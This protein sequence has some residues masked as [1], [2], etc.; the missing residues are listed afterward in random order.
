MTTADL[1]HPPSP[2]RSP[3]LLE[4]IRLLDLLE[5]TGNALQTGELLQLSQP[6]ISRHN[7]RLAADLGLQQYP[8]CAA[9]PLRYGDGACLRL[10]RRASKRHRLDAGVWRLG[11]D[12][13]GHGSLA[14]DLRVLPVPAR[15]RPLLEW[16]A[17][18]R[19][20]LLDGA[21]VS[22]EE[23]RLHCS[24]L[25]ANHQHPWAWEGCML[26]P[27]GASPLQLVQPKPLALEGPGQTVA[28]WSTVLMPALSS[29][30]GLAGRL[31]QQQLRPIHLRS[32]QQQPEHWVEALAERAHYALV[33]PCWLQQ[34]QAVST[35]PLVSVALPKALVMEH[36]LLVHRRDWGKHGGLT[37]MTASLRDRINSCIPQA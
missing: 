7:R 35:R 24:D 12:G 13:W 3:E 29:C 18:V 19:A 15:F 30:C 32:T 36:W 9:V 4:D 33:T 6:T 16:Q 21:L 17:L 27:L 5:L 37:T 34:L 31:R 22:G 28:R 2:Y 23:L 14:Q 20:H 8:R 26:I 11:S 1:P 25:P 10:L